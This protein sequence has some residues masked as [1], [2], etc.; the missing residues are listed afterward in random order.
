MN[1]EE[2]SSGAAES[3]RV[4]IL[5][6]NA[7]MGFLLPPAAMSL[8]PEYHSRFLLREANRLVPQSMYCNCVDFEQL[9]ILGRIA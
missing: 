2:D 8:R 1:V 5:D 4:P 7:K 9:A 3:S 6:S